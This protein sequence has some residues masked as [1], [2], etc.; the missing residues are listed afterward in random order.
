MRDTT[1]P[2]LLA[3]R[4]GGLTPLGRTVMDAWVFGLLPETQ[5]CSGWT[6]GQMEELLERVYQAWLPHGHLP[7]RLPDQLRER[8]ARIYQEALARAHAVGWEPDMEAE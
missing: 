5:T 6:I 1:Y 3:D 2:G 4:G 7:S 8:H